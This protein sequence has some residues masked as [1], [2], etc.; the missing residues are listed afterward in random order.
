LNKQTHPFLH[1]IL[2][3][4]VEKGQEEEAIKVANK[5]SFIPHFTHSLEL[6]L[7]ETLEDEFQRLGKS[8][9][10]SYNGSINNSIF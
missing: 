5:Y 2:R 10:L 3:Y 1:S 4:L 9:E 8:L 7:Y 6:L